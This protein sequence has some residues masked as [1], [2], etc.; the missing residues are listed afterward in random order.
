MLITI[1]GIDGSGKSTLISAL[2]ESLK[3][4]DPVFT[5]E[6][7][8]TWVGDA[9]R[10]AIAEQADP[11]TEALLFVADHAA[12]LEAVIRPALAEGR[13]VI[14]DR[15]T[16]SRYAYQG[17]MLEGRIP[18]PLQWLRALHDGWTVVPDRT[19]LLV[20][21]V[22]TALERLPGDK[23]R[24]H[25]ED[26][27]FLEKVQGNYLALAEADAGRFVLV[28]AL[29]PAGEICR[30]VEKEIRRLARSPRSRRRR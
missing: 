13:T 1:E 7:G 10:R 12:H 2:R 26:G 27:P 29:L 18:E 17:V 14:S 28:D 30:F 23:R 4:L 9:V 5:R 25:F 8:S 20:I 16:D 11:V 19:F 24:E 6:P 21:P 15:Y 3:D 22:E